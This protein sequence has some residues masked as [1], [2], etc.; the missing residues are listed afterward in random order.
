MNAIQRIAAVGVAA[1]ALPAAAD[2][3][4]FEHDNFNGR[5]VTARGPVANL[6]RFG[7]NDQV[8]SAVVDSGVYEVCEHA[9]FGGHCTLLGPGEYRSFNRMGFN[10]Q[11]SS[12]RPVA[13][14]RLGERYYN[15]PPIA[16]EERYRRYYY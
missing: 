13:P 3:T 7:F 5:A 9:D 2:I 16:Y 15:P 4:I 8:S 12:V 6:D 11:V 14:E 10:D 1:L